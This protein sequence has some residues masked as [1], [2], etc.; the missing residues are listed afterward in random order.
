MLEEILANLI[1][2]LFLSSSDRAELAK[3]SET[4]TF[5]RDEWIIR[6]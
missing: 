4:L 3:Q 1:P 6:R 5:S 2:F